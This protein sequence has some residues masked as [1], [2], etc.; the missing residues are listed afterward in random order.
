MVETITAKKESYDSSF[1]CGTQ[2][3]PAPLATGL[4]SLV[5]V[6]SQVS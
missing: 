5:L 4:R 6:S 1:S 2:L 3:P